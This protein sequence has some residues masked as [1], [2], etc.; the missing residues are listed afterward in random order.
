MKNLLIKNAHKME[1][2]ITNNSPIILTAVGVVGVVGTV[3]VTHKATTKA[4]Q[5][6]ANEQYQR[7]IKRVSPGDAE[8]LDRKHKIKA[9]W[10][11]YAPVVGIAGLSIAAIIGAQ[12]INTKRAAALAAG[13]MVLESKHEE[14][15]EKV[16]ELFGV[17]K[18]SD[19][20]EAVAKD[21]VHAAGDHKVTVHAGDVLCLDALTKQ[22]FSSNMET[23]RKA[24]NNINAR[25][26]HGEQCS[27]TD[28][29]AELEGSGL[30]STR[31]TEAFGWN[32][33]NMCEMKFTSTLDDN[34]VAYLV[35]DFSVLPVGQ[36][37]K[38]EDPDRGR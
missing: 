9:T 20:D 38:V 25:I 30:Q 16:E 6:L 15:K 14:Y 19:V 26:N 4:N 7:N 17:K 2:L 24:E 31:L 21:L 13:Y 22:V 36:F 35:M 32:D 10:K 28:L 34:G 33:E 23:L 1:R 3:V 29:F 8:P 27:V 11:C 5:I 37:W 12:Y 18:A